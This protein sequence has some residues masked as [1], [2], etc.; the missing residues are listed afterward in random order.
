MRWLPWLAIALVGCASKTGDA[1][2][3]LGND[4]ASC[5]SCHETHY[6]EWAASS[7]ATS[8]RSPLLEAMLPDVEAAWGAFA[9]QT[10][11]GCHAPE[12]GDDEGI[13]CVSCHAAVGNQSPRDGQLRVDLTVPLAGPLD[14]PAETPAHTSRPSGFLASPQLCGTCHELTGPN[15]V[16]EPTLTEHLA[17]PQAAMGMGCMDCHMPE[18][19]PRAL[20]D[21]GPE[22][23]TR[24]HRFV[25]F[26]PPWGADRETA[27]RHAAQTRQLL[28]DALDLSVTRADG[29][30]EITVHNVGAGHAVP[31]GATF[32]RDLW[33]DVEHD[34]EIVAARVLQLG[35]QPMQ[36]DAPVAL[37][38]QADRVEVHS[39]AAGATRTAVV[40]VD[41]PVRVVLRG[42]AVRASVLEAL[43][44]EDRSA[45]V[46]VHVIESH[47]LP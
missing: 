46:P 32:L 42:R 30:V 41:G 26:D 3:P 25:G 37:L 40:D 4:G 45:E 22:R 28:D 14:D 31:T 11:E 16:E 24:S 19:A 34:G 17:S 1:A 21:E 12:H 44:L 35:D 10:C 8:A 39:L 33:V 43:S 29:G 38:T 36:A 27:E 5:G 9:R 15:L 18:T 6:D 7:H 13:G 47:P 2:L 23:A 20:T